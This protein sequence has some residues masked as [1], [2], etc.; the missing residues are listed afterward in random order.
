MMKCVW[1]AD[2]FAT[3]IASAARYRRYVNSSLLYLM[4]SVLTA[5]IALLINPAMAS[6]LSPSD[7]ALLG[8]L[9]SFNYI[10]VPLFSFSLVSYFLRNY[11]KLSEE[12]REVVSD[13]ILIALTAYGFMAL[14]GSLSIFYIYARWSGLNFSYYPYVLLAFAPV[15]LNNMLV[16]F[17]VTCRVRRDAAKFCLVTVL[18]A[19]LSAGFALLFVV[20]YESGA[21]GRLSATLIASL[22]TAVYCFRHLFKKF[23]FDH[24]VIKEAFLFGWP[25]SVS[26]MLWYFFNGVDSM[27]LERLHDSYTFGYYNVGLQIA[28]YL[29][30]FY[31]AVAQ[32]FEPDIYQA[33]S[34][35][36]VRRLFYLIAGILFL[37]SLPNLFYICFTREILDI[38]TA[39]HYLGAEA[40]SK[41]FAIKNIAMGVYY[42]SITVIIAYGF[43][44]SELSIRIVGSVICLLMFNLLIKNFAFVGAAW[45]QVASFVMMSTLNGAYI[46][47]MLRRRGA[48][49]A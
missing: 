29:S 14:L 13:T 12:R 25:I 43:P 41:I 15:Y 38:L 36:N 18:N 8:Y 4:S 39:G 24:A 16:F 9:T 44:K 30:L 17:Q 1:M 28:G 7:Y 33:V 26:T 49:A 34:V 3:A 23:R 11:F 6:N 37:N 35:N 31:T 20:H 32:T 22:F 47:Y 19:L 10:L 2:L 48:A 5:A 46:C 42:S 27:M 40:F 21:V 45:G